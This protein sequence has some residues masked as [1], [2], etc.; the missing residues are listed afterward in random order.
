MSIWRAISVGQKTD[1]TF[2]SS[3]L[4]HLRPKNLGQTFVALAYDLQFSAP[5]ELL[6]GKE[7]ASNARQQF[8]LVLTA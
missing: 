4:L 8:P 6:T 2:R 7:L 1:L 3:A 5:N